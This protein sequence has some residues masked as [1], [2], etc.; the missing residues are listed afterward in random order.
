M[1]EFILNRQTELAELCR[2]F[3]V[4]RLLLFGSSLTDAFDQSASD[5]DFVVEFQPLVE[6]EHAANYFGLAAAL[7]MLFGR[8]VDLLESEAIRN[9]YI[10]QEIDRTHQLLYGA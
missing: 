6:S 5:L 4:R 2:R 10:R 3:R 9:P 7:E 1:K 8:P